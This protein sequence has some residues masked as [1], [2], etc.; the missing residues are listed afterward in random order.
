VDKH[1]E[2]HYRIFKMIHANPAVS[3]RELAREAGVSLGKVHYC[4]QAL[5]EKGL[6][7]V[8]NFRRNDNK[9]PYAYL[10]TPAGIAEKVRVT[11][12]FLQ[13]KMVEFDALRDEIEALRREEAAELAPDPLQS[14]I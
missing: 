12:R 4:V 7:K 14:K 1:D 3:Q 11:R 13:R 5:V 8:E 9:L 6:I 10:I 2:I